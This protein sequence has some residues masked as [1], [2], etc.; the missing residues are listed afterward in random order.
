MTAAPPTGEPA[1]VTVTA[2]EP[3]GI[4][5]VV[6]VVLPAVTFTP[7]AVPVAAASVAEIE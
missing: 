6:D 5:T 1:T 7:V 2:S 4:A 3:T